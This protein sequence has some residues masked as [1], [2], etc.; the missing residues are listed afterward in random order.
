MTGLSLRRAHP[1]PAL[2]CTLASALVHCVALTL[3][4]LLSPTR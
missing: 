4:R 3:G 1:L 2:A